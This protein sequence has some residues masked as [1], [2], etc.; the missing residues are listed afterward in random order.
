MLFLRHQCRKKWQHGDLA[1]SQ[2]ASNDCPFRWQPPNLLEASP[3]PI[4]LVRHVFSF[5]N[6]LQW[7]DSSADDVGVVLLSV[8]LRK[9]SPESSHIPTMSPGFS[10]DR[11][12][13]ISMYIPEFE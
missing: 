6:I 7:S 4:F 3:Q 5:F 2:R 11:K 9:N 13:H 8:S 1:C 10:S 12:L